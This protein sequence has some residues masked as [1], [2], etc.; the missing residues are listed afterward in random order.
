MRAATSLFF[1][2]LVA[3]CGFIPQTVSL[4]DPRIK[5]LLDAIAAVD[6]AA[7]GF[8]PIEPNVKVR[9][10]SRPRRDYDQMLHIYGR[11]S[12]RISFRRSGS[13][14]R[15]T[16]E[17]E[18]YTGPHTYDSVDGKYR[19]QITVTYETESVATHG[20]PLN[21]LQITYH[22]EDQRLRWSARLQRD[23]IKPV[24]REWGYQ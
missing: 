4:S 17:Q 14:F 15:W 13:G 20:Y 22:G 24:L 12:R 3:G 16:G 7:L 1:C 5:P 6:R 2:L 18:I 8:T 11:T 9:W 21:Q 23:D 19:E 10:E